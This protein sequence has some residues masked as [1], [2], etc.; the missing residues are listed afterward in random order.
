MGKFLSSLASQGKNCNVSWA[1]RL[2]ISLD[3]SETHETTAVNSRPQASVIEMPN[4]EIVTAL[5]SLLSKKR[6]TNQKKLDDVH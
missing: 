4:I 5:K 6:G 2:K 1:V 3:C